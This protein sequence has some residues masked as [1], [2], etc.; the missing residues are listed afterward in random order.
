MSTTMSDPK[1]REQA[2]AASRRPSGGQE[3]PAKAKAFVTGT[4][5]V[6]LTLMAMGLRQWESANLTQY[7]C[8]LTLALLA[9]T[10]KIR[11]PRITG[12]MSVN[13]LFIL[14]GV[15]NFSLSET[16]VIGC[17]ATLIQC[18]WNAKQWPTPLQ[19]TFNIAA[20]GISTAVAYQVPRW[21]LSAV[22]QESLTVLLVMATVLFF[23]T[24]TVLI[25]TV[26]A[27][28][29]SKPLDTVWRQCYLWSFPYYVVGAAIAALISAE[30]RSIGWAAALLILP[31]MYLV[32]VFYAMFVARARHEDFLSLGIAE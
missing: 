24:N 2:P 4:V 28:L 30:S 31:L 8:Y 27:L 16:L 15:A 9:S 32:Y 18:F 17:T 6:G 12:T 19:V 20:L 5:L 23:L 7:V 1:T 11:L 13:F 29:E 3:M 14:I 21:V 22:H 25:S 26:L 10:W